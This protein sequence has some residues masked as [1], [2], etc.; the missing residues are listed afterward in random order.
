MKFSELW[1]LSAT[2]YKEISFQSIFSLRAG[3]SLPQGGRRDIKQLVANARV[4][5]LVSK[6]VTT[7]FLS[8]FA[9]I[10]FLPSIIGDSAPAVPG[11]TTVLG[12]VSAFLTVVLFLIAFMGLQIST[13][14]VSSKIPELLGPLP[15]SRRDISRIIF[16]CFIRIFDIP[17]ISAVIVFLIAYFLVGGTLLGGVISSAGIIT[18]EAFALTLTTLL[19]RFFYAKVAAAG[20]RSR[21]QTLL[22][23]VFMFVWILP[24]FAAYFVVNFARQIVESFAALTLGISAS[25]FLVLVYP[26]SYGV[27]ASYATFVQSID[28]AILGMSV[29]ASAGYVVLAYV[30]L[31]WLTTTIRTIGTGTVRSFRELVKDVQIRPQIPWL[32]VMHKD[33]RVASRAPSFASLFL[34]PV[35]QTAILAFTFSSSNG[36]NLTTTLG[37]LTGISMLTLLLPPTLLAIEGLASTYTR[38][39][40]VKKRTLITAKTLLAMVTYT[41]S[42]TMLSAIA[43]YLGRDLSIFSF[44]MSHVLSVGAAVMLELTI[45]I[46]KFWKEGL[47]VGNIYSRISTYIIILI[48]GYFVASL[49]IIAA[50]M[51]LFSASHLILP[52]FFTVAISEFALMAAIVARE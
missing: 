9:V 7:V 6:L 33:V 50:F 14:F 34:L 52:I 31:R 40:P 21:W 4:S 25:Q 13:S 20:G 28:Y 44:G 38:H 23:L 49:P 26:F 10:V 16:L 30:C 12:G 48:P 43:Y 2:V 15:L 5:T 29:V 19:S 37:V 1:R 41:L 36:F 39:L 22:R 17:L 27:L 18:A 8:V 32:A 46:R 11:E 51:A 3:S 45:L 42:L 24:T 47:P 35:I